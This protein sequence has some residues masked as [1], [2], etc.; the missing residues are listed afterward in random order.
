MAP[1]CR[2]HGPLRAFALGGLCL[3]GGCVTT[4]EDAPLFGKVEAPAVAA[5]SLTIPFGDG[6]AGADQGLVAAFYGGVLGRMHEAAKDRD[7]AGLEA[8]LASY[9]RPD[10]PPG[11]QARITAYRAVARGLRFQQHVL[12]ATKL[13]LVPAATDGSTPWEVGAPALG[14]A[15]QFTLELPAPPDPVVLGGEGDEDRAGFLVSFVVEDDFVEGGSRRSSNSVPVWLP[16][17]VALRGDTVLTLP[18]TIDLP[19][20][21]AVRRQVTVRVDLMPG[22]VQHEQGRSPVGRTTIA[23]TVLRQW[24]VGYGALTKAPLAE[25]Q[26]ALRTFGPAN[27]AR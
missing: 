18:I 17:A 1:G 5:S 2:P 26:A 14:A 11:V 12:A 16:A 24:P 3:L 20:D 27:Y 10:L 15:L 21:Q 13:A 7:V 4:Y 25:L 6:N 22:H 19:S 9:D 23:A 8:M